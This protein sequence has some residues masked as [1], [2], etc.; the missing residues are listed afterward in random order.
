MEQP[1]RTQI[2]CARRAYKHCRSQLQRL[3]D[4]EIILGLSLEKVI[5][6]HDRR[7]LHVS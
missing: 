4:L 5:L 3:D 7:E 1:L 6:V 2:P